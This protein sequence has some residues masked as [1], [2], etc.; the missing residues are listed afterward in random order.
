MRQA[1][2]GNETRYDSMPNLVANKRDNCLYN[3]LRPAVKRKGQQ[4]IIGHCHVNERKQTDLTR[5]DSI[6]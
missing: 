6:C 4:N 1:T 5:Q 2:E 3:I